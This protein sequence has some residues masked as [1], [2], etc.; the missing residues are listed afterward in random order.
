VN[1]HTEHTIV[2][3]VQFKDDNIEEGEAPRV[4]LATPNP[5]GEQM[6][7]SRGGQGNTVLKDHHIWSNGVAKGIEE[8]IP[9][10]WKLSKKRLE[11]LFN[12]NK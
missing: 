10:E 6:K 1:K 11:N 5:I 4:Y 2:S 3:L 8:R 9:S 12:K 7:K